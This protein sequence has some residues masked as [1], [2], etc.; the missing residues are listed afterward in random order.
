MAP[1]AGEDA[2][3]LFYFDFARGGTP[4]AVPGAEVKRIRWCPGRA[5][6]LAWKTVRFPP[7]ELFAGSADLYHFPNFTIPP[8]SRGRAVVSIHDMSFVRHPEFAETRNLRH[9]TATI[10]ATARRADAIIT[11]S[12]FSAGE[13]QELLDVPAERIFPIYLG[14]SPAFKRPAEEAIRPVLDRHGLKRPY[15]LT[16]GTLEPRKNVPF[17]VEVFERMR[18]F[19][20]DLVIAGMPGWKYEPILQRLHDS[21]RAANIRYVRYF[22]DDALPALY[23]GASL[24]MLPSFYE[25]FGFPPLEAMACGTP[26]LTSRGGSLAEVLGDAAVTLAEYDS[27]LW[28][29]TAI[30]L[31]GDSQRMRTL[32]EGGPAHAARYT[33]EETAR[34][35]LEL[36]RRVAA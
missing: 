3:R 7:F 25:G 33:W 24:F 20:G 17:L 16:V 22:D 23:A 21:P 1:L 8:L 19:D 15:L 27:E 14:I 2:L 9:L 26:A 32:R 29:A 31:L 18:G 13:I 6:Q 10:R 36:Y 28:A 5:A 11:I 12:Q 35:T 30:Q 34:R 4:F